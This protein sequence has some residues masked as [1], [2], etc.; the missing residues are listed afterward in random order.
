MTRYLRATTK[1]ALLEDLAKNSL[2]FLNE[3]GEATEPQPFQTTTNEKGAVAIYLGQIVLEPAEVDEEGNVV[4]E[5]TISEEYCANVTN[6]DAIFA[7][8]MSKKPSKPY[9]VFAE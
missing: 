5:A 1:E 2:T 7:T 9:N 8:E 3:E 6:T 4:K